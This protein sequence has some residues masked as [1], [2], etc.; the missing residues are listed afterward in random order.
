MDVEMSD[1]PL[2]VTGAIIPRDERILIAQRHPTS[3][4]EPSK[5]EFPGGKVDF[6]EHP[7]ES[8]KRELKEEMG[9]EIETGPLYEVISHVY[10]NNGDIRH[11]VLLFYICR[12]LKGKPEPLDC[13]DLCWVDKEEMKSLPFVE[14]DIPLVDQ[15]L[16][17]SGLWEIG[18]TT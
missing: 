4:F 6:G 11:V 10:N 3:R 8:L 2:L 9:V 17:D 16:I 15:I 12:I 7:E 1:R 18:S 5:W 13:Q 14:G